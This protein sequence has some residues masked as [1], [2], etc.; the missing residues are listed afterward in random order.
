MSLTLPAS[1]AVSSK[2]TISISLPPVMET[3]IYAVS[4]SMLLQQIISCP[5]SNAANAFPDISHI[6]V[7]LPNSTYSL[8]GCSVSCSL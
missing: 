4:S 7:S 5:I 3:D 6:T 8:T 2:M 1:A